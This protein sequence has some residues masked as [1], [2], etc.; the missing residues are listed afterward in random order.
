MKQGVKA[1]LG[2]CGGGISRGRE[3]GAWRPGRVGLCQLWEEAAAADQARRIWRT[4]VNELAGRMH[5]FLGGSF[6]VETGELLR[7]NPEASW[8]SCHGGYDY[9]TYFPLCSHTLL[10]RGPC[11]SPLS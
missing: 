11:L 6:G 5:R 3:R 4:W 8:A 7:E 9:L 2:V 10:R 1:C